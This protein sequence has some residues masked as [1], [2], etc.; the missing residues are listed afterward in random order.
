M[1]VLLVMARIN[2]EPAM[3]RGM[4]IQEG[5]YGN[6]SVAPSVEV[7]AFVKLV[8]FLGEEAAMEVVQQ[9]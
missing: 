8:I 6:I 5:E 1:N 2:V 4:Y 7:L 9:D 3:G